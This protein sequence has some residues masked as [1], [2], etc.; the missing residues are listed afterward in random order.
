[1]KFF[2]PN[3]DGINDVWEISGLLD[4]NQEEI[5]LQIYNRYGKLLKTFTNNENGWDGTYNGRDLPSDDYW[6]RIRLT[7]G[8]IETGNF[9]LKR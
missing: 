5:L 2:T 9:T 7:D 4:N 6:Y 3:G 8:T 1:M